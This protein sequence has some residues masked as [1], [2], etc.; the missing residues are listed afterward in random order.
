[1]HA[2]YRAISSL[3]IFF[4]VAACDGGRHI[5][6]ARRWQRFPEEKSWSPPG[7]ANFITLKRVSAQGADPKANPAIFEVDFTINTAPYPAQ[8]NVRIYVTSTG[9]LRMVMND[10]VLGTATCLRAGPSADCEQ[11]GFNFTPSDEF[12]YTAF[13]VS[14]N[15]GDHYHLSGVFDG[16][17]QRYD[18]G[19]GR[20][21][22]VV[23]TST[24]GT[25][26]GRWLTI[27]PSVT[28]PMVLSEPKSLFSGNSDGAFAIE[29]KMPLPRT[30]ANSRTLILS[31][32]IAQSWDVPTFLSAPLPTATFPMVYRRFTD[33]GESGQFSFIFEKVLPGFK[34]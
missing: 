14:W 4:L 18:L 3:F 21:E 24:L 27:Q 8:G 15:L 26:K 6:Q 13:T 32:D 2:T 29:L 34:K 12:N 23:A 28:A 7:S 16:Q 17:T 22:D 9:Q 10:A 5:D 25:F 30:D 20:I 1:M 19:D 11:Y 33:S 31:T